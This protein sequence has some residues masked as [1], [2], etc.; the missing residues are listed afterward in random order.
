MEPV[1]E[2]S[3]PGQRAPAPGRLHLVQRFVNTVDFEHGREM[4]SEPGRL[5]SVL[6]E[7]GL[8]ASGV[9]VTDADLRRALAVR[10]AL[11]ALAL[12]NNGRVAD[13]AAIDV[14]EQ[15]A[16]AGRLVVEFDDARAA[17]LEAAAPG[18]AGALGAL[19]GIVYTAMADGTWGRL[20][21]CQRDVCR[22]LFY[23]GSRN[24]SARWCQMAVC[25]N[26]TK[27][28]AYRARRR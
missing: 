17:R 12:A 18:V 13:R 15:A 28:R 16:A 10:E 26:R 5:R 22:W 2:I 23:D 3:Y 21:A 14:L 4:L 25:G 9:R 11:R 8:L 19:V 7:F 6:A 27:T 1:L 24:R 20:K